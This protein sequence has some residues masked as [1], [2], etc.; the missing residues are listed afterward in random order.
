MTSHHSEVRQDLLREEGDFSFVLGGPLFQLLRRLHLSG[1]TLELVRRR[2]VIISLFLW[3]PLLVLSILGG[4]AL[5]GGVAVPFLKD[6]DV[7]VRFLLV[8]PLLLVSELVIHKRLRF[9]SR[10]F[11]QRALVPPAARPRFEATLASAFR[12]RNSTLAE[13]V[14]VA[15]V[16]GVGILLVWRHYTA[17]VTNTWYATVAADG[18]LTLS[19]AGIW[20]VY[21][22]VPVFQFFLLRWYYRIFI[23]TRF[24]WQV[25]RLELN[26]MPTHPDGVGGLGFLS[27][28]VFAFLPLAVAHGGIVG[29]WIAN[30]IFYGGTTLLAFKAELVVLVVLVLAIVLVPLLAFAPQLAHLKRKGQRDYGILAER[31]VQE[32]DA[33]WLHGS[34]PPQEEL[35]GHHDI[36]S[37]A[38][39]MNSYATIQRIRLAPFGRQAIIGL[40]AATLLPVAPLLLTMVPA[41]V[42]LKRLFGMLF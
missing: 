7:H 21:L 14:L 22:S 24:L 6:I 40:A 26:L 30:R 41:D 17:L 32:F 38:D 11:L 4:Q 12:L 15:V 28:T 36:Q 33:K 20:Y 39:M 8:M 29:G 19:P 34:S 2:V 31:Y 18:G 16:Y 37:L 42:L 3:L 5:G 27:G 9:V 35:L 10:Q 13:L 25:S 23:W 1:E